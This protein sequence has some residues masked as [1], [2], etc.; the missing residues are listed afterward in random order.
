MASSPR[1][2]KQW[3]LSKNGSINS[4]ENWRQNLVYTLSLDSNF[5]PF[6][7]DGTTWEKKTKT[8]PLRGLTRR[9]INNTSLQTPYCA[10]ESQFPGAYARANCQLLSSDISE[11]LSE[12]FDLYPVCL[13]HDT[14]TFWHQDVGRRC[15][16]SCF[17]WRH[18]QWLTRTGW[19]A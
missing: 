18:C 19:C 13:E 14:R 15:D 3:S 4:L 5:A 9:W 6:L 10:A 16:E 7:A 8:Q 17:L 12:E 2:P 1:A 11:Y